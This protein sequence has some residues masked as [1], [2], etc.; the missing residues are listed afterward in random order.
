LE[1]RAGERVGFSAFSECTKSVG[2]G[3]P[4][5]RTRA[6]VIRLAPNGVAASQSSWLTEPRSK[7]RSSRT[8]AVEDAAKGPRSSSRQG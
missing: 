1:A 3:R 5:C 4:I 8:Y 2:I 6:T 7:P